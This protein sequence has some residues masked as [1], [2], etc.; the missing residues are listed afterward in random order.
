MQRVGRALR[1]TQG[2]SEWG[3]SGARLMQVEGPMS[4]GRGCGEEGQLAD[5]LNRGVFVSSGRAEHSE[6][7]LQCASKAGGPLT[8]RNIGAR[9]A[10]EL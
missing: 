4:V 9:C 7:R 5:G 6:A 3:D 8:G 1:Y 10:N 2:E